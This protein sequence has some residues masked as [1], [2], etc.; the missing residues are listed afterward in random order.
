MSGAS[1]TNQ[2]VLALAAHSVTSN[3]SHSEHDPIC[4]ARP[5]S[6][7]WCADPAGKSADG[8]SPDISGDLD[9][10][11]ALVSDEL[12]I[13]GYMLLCVTQIVS[14]VRTEL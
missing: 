6:L 5:R 14:E 9:Q 3:C 13:D 10:A 11:R 4:V 12:S 2:S 8:V 7:L 1:C